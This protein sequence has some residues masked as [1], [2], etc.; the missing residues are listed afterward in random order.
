MP[1]DQLLEAAS[2]PG[3]RFQVTVDVY[4]FPKP[5]V[6]IYAAGEQAHVPLLVGWNSAEMSYQSLIGPDKPTIE[7]Y[8]KAVQ[9]LYGDKSADVMKYYGAASEDHVIQ[10]A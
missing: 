8:S 6:Q 2:I 10:A 7:R 4:F 9:K 1:A 3:T 5:P